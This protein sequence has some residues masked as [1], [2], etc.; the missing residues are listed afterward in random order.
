MK[1]GASN[2]GAGTKAL[3]TTV[4]SRRVAL[5]GSG[6]SPLYSLGFLRPIWS[7]F[8]ENLTVFNRDMWGAR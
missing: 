7:I 1:E 2:A 3:S 4:Y 8:N 5:G 6:W